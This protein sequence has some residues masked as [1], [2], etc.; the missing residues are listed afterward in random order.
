VS[1]LEKRKAVSIPPTGMTPTRRE[2][3]DM[4]E[5][6]PKRVAEL[7]AE[8]AQ[9]RELYADRER[10]LAFEYAGR[11]EAEANF[12]SCN[13][14]RQLA[15]TEVKRLRGELAFDSILAPLD[16]AEIVALRVEVERLRNAL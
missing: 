11:M 2:G 6:Y 7:T 14:A 1:A 10:D 5:W 15:E 8:L 13:R 3:D 9:L 16:S 12:E 4:N